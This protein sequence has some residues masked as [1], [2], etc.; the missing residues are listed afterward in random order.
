MCG[1]TFCIEKVDQSS[2][3]GLDEWNELFQNVRTANAAR[4]KQ[5]RPGPME[6]R[7]I[8]RTRF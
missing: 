4:G 1:I 5:E 7:I 8:H 6:Q 2:E 3:D